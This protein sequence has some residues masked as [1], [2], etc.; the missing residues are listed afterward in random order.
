MPEQSAT[1]PPIDVVRDENEGDVKF[2]VWTYAGNV[3]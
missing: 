3:I 2:W 1:G